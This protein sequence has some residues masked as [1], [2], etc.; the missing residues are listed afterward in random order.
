MRLFDE[1]LPLLLPRPQAT[2]HNHTTVFSQCV[3][4]G[5]QALLDSVV[6]EPAG[7][8]DDQIGPFKG[9][10][11]LIALCTQTSQNQF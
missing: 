5:I 9:F 6:N 3:R 4:D 10:A 8:D 11:G 7:V 2:R 1:V